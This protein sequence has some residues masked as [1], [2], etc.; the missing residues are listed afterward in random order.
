MAKMVVQFLTVRLKLR[1][2]KNVEK[3]VHV[4]RFPVIKIWCMVIG[5]LQ[6]VCTSWAL[7]KNKRCLNRQMFV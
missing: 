4:N 2:F 6:V 5:V 3:N 7:P 1:K